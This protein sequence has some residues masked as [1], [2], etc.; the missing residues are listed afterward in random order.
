MHLKEYFIL[1]CNIS[2]KCLYKKKKK[3]LKSGTY[4]S[5]LRKEHKQTGRTIKT[6]G[7]LMK[8]KTEKLEIFKEK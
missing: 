1:F 6:K 4:T 3:A 2:I 8:V 7:K 5:T